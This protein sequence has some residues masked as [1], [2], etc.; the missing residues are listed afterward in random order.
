MRTSKQG[1]E[2]IKK[3]EGLRLTSY[4]L[5]SEKKY[6]IGYGHYGVEANLTITKE[7]AEE[8]L[9]QDLKTAENQVNKY[10]C[11]YTFTQNQFDALVSFAYNIGNIK[12]LTRE[13]TRTK[14]EIAEAIL[15]Y[16][17]SGGKVLKGLVARRQA[18]R[19]LFL[20]TSSVLVN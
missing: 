1:L 19:K 8:Y 17:K 9:I 15:R 14:T 6:T 13:G 5:P 20:T 10:N 4:Q 2:L 16:N 12:Q 11:I 7:V 18:E 3:F